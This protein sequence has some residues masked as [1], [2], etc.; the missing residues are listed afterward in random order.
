MDED[1]SSLVVLCRVC[2]ELSCRRISG[3]WVV[4]AML[5]WIIGRYHLC[6][7]GWLVYTILP[8]PYDITAGIA[9][10]VLCTEYIE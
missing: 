7:G 10:G 1:R 2:I 8:R 9:M 4:G 5:V 6:N 3:L